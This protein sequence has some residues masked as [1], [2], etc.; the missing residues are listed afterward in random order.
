MIEMRTF[1]IK[2]DDAVLVKL[3]ALEKLFFPF[4]GPGR[5]R[6]QAVRICIDL[7]Y[8]LFIEG[9]DLR[10]LRAFVRAVR[11]FQK[12]TLDGLSRAPRG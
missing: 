5:L 9:E 4:P 10:A 12:K 7:V 6:G 8:R 1:S 11:R 3:E 2:M